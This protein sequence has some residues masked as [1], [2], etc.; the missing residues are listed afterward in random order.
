LFAHDWSGYFL[1]EQGY[2]VEENI[3]FQDNR[4]T[5]LLEKNGKASSSKQIN[6]FNIRFYFVTLNIQG[7]NECAMVPNER[8]DR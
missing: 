2:N 1:L 8:H 6:H 3:L 4:S 5:M 7:R